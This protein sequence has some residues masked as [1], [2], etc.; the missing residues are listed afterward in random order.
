MRGG[1]LLLHALL[2]LSIDLMSFRAPRPPDP[3][4]AVS[5]PRRGRAP[6]VE[7]IS[8]SVVA[9]GRARHAVRGR[10]E[11]NRIDRVRCGVSRVG[12]CGEYGGDQ[13]VCYAYGG[14]LFFELMRRRGRRGRAPPAA[15]YQTGPVRVRSKS[16][17]N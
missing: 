15:Q 11:W 2:I 9:A 12:G 4:P 10:L 6:R 3:A 13:S 7:V 8:D 5:R 16:K 17:R 14:D 1:A